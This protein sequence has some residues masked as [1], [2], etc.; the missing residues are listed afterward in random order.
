MSAT[1]TRDLNRLRPT[2][3]HVLGGAAAFVATAPALIG[4]KARAAEQVVVRTSGGAYAD[5]ITPTIYEP[6]TKETGIEVVQVPSTIGKLYAMFRSGNIELDVINTDQVVLLGLQREGALA[7]LDYASWKFSDPAQIDK[8]VKLPHFAGHLYFSWVLTYN[9]EVFPDGKHP[10]S[11]AEFWDAKRF[12]GPRTLPDLASGQPPLEF[13]LL[14]DGVPKDKIYPLDLNRAFKSLDRIRPAVKKFWDTGAL[15]AELLTSKEAV[16]GALWNAR[17]QPIID[18]GGPISIEWNESM[19]TCMGYSIFKGAKNMKNA[20]R[21]IDF[22]MQPKNLAAFLS[23]YPY[24]PAVSKA[25]DFMSPDALSRLPTTPERR[26]KA[27]ALDIVWW[28]DNRK[29]VSD[30]WSKWLLNR[31]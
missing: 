3:R 12:P 29:A 15:S 2:R 24:G 25:L 16:L 14:A 28:E 17:V 8:A 20:Q 1:W 9:R 10:H 6:F 27:L 5:S 4:T 30:R 7:D 19:Y 21:L 31:A 22:A 11:W 18:A 13:A 23:R 26:E